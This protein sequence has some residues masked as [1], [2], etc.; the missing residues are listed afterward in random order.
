MGEPAEKHSKGWRA[1]CV[2]GCTS[3][4]EH[5]R[6]ITY[7]N[8]NKPAHPPTRDLADDDGL[9]PARAV[10][11]KGTMGNPV[12]VRHYDYDR[13]SEPLTHGHQDPSPSGG[14]HG[15]GAGR[16]HELAAHFVN[17]QQSSPLVTPLATL[18]TRNDP[19][20]GDR[21]LI[22]HPGTAA[23]SRLD[24]S[25]AAPYGGP[26]PSGNPAMRRMDHQSRGSAI[27]PN[28]THTLSDPASHA[29]PMAAKSRV[30]IVREAMFGP[31]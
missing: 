2:H 11:D 3:R 5:H 29:A 19:G 25:A 1:T 28:G 18:T 27:P 24:A 13:L 20:N 7:E 15:L 30:E 21:D 26:V 14:D 12:P 22:Y 4:S 17:L 8:L 6:R 9:A 23:V 31:R 16:P 10:A